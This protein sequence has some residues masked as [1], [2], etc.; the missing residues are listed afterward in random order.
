[1]TKDTRIKV[2][3]L[4]RSYTSCLQVAPKRAFIAAGK[5]PAEAMFDDD[6]ASND[7]DNDDT[8]PAPKRRKRPARLLGHSAVPSARARARRR[9]AYKAPPSAQR[10][11][12]SPTWQGSETGAS[13]ATT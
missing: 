6:Y 13:R 2:R 9:T 10:N 3:L 8:A 1:M 12:S 4:G 5:D 7:E 11:A